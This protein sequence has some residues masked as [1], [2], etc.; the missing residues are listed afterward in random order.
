MA[1]GSVMSWRGLRSRGF[2]ESADRKD[3]GARCWL[4]GPRVAL[5]F[6]ISKDGSIFSPILAGRSEEKLGEENWRRA[7]KSGPITASGILT[8][9]RGFSFELI[10]DLMSW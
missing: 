7:G 8:S 5:G 6:E 10:S 2:E 9:R 1:F 4:S 3:G